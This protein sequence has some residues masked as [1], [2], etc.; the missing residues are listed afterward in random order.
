MASRKLI[1][2]ADRVF[3]KYIR[4]RDSEDGFFICCSCGQ[5]KPFEQAD[6]GHFI[7]RR[8]M[9]LRYDE[10]NRFDEGNMVGYTR[11]ML[12]TY[13]E[14]IVDLLE[15]MKT[16]YKWTDGELEILI[17]YWKDKL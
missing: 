10:R 8:W 16:P 12:K 6:A 1:K 2:K 9:A 3:S 17:K 14:G 13:G 5:R 11:F 7:N 4:L 15:S